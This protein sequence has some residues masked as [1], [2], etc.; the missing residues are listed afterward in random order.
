MK[1]KNKILLVEPDFPISPKSKNHKNFL[2]I[3]L[4]KIASYLRSNG[5]KIKLMRGIPRNLFDIKDIE[6]FKPNE[7]W[8]TSLFT[9]WAEYVKSAVES[10]KVIFPKAK[11]LVG[12][13]YASLMPEHCKEFTCCD[14]VHVGI[15]ENAER[16]PPAYDLVENMNSHKIDYQI[17]H[18]SRGCN[19]KC[20][21]CGTWKIEPK[22]KPKKSIKKEI[23]LRKIVF[24]DNNFFA[25]P[26]IE[27]ILKELI[28]L[29]KE[30]KLLWCESQSGF[31]G[32]IM[33][34]K[35]HLAKMLKKSGFRYP[36][37]SWDWNY[38]ECPLI[39]EQIKLLKDAGYNSKE[40]FIFVLYNW[41]INL[42]EMEQKRL[43]CWDWKVQIADCRYRPLD[44]T[45]DY[46]NPKKKQ[47]DKNYYIPPN[48]TD[49]EVKQF[50]KNVR[51]QNIC[52]RQDVSFYSRK[53]ENKQ[54]SKEQTRKLK[55]MKTASVKKI[56]DDAW[57]PE[58]LEIERRV[59]GIQFYEEKRR[60]SDSIFTK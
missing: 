12:G 53:L 22:F 2:P 24:Y 32:R 44:Q 1:K 38:S 19:R 20:S 16:F 4:L 31:D 54:L 14:E 46:Y 57:F 27:N 51:R 9:Y 29:K 43:K 56:L 33:L 34:E 23:K 10:Y 3:G 8:I 52:V 11:L 37:I 13:I 39:E 6:D 18:A 42:K 7:I 15:L 36:R 58:D 48:W 41:E 49:E 28:E 5:V 45:T 21:F 40:I 55:R 26:Y 30:K 25:N 59:L 35:P 47:S 60:E 50:R 17:I